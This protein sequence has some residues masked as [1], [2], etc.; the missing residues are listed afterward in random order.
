MSRNNP[1]RPGG[2]ASTGGALTVSCWLPALL[3]AILPALWLA[4]FPRRRRVARRRRLG[5]CPHRGYDLRA[6]PGRCPECGDGVSVS[7][8]T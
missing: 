1:G 2:T 5:L 6:T 3:S 8:V 7:P 4:R